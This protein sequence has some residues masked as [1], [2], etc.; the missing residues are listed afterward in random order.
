MFVALGSILTQN[1]FQR[2]FMKRGRK[3]A[4]SCPPEVEVEADCKKVARVETEEAVDADL[5]VPNPPS[6]AEL[7]ERLRENVIQHGMSPERANQLRVQHFRFFRVFC[8]GMFQM[9][10]NETTN[11]TR[12]TLL[13]RQQFVIPV[14]FYQALARWRLSERNGNDTDSDDRAEYSGLT[15]S[16]T[17]REEPIITEPQNP[18]DLTEEGQSLERMHD[19]IL[20]RS[21]IASSI[22]V[23]V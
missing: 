11:S 6:D 1:G 9:R 7:L 17:V 2:S 12:P 18:T 4:A 5:A 3:R 8:E 20:L 10:R 13:P 14:T 19:L 16:S 22:G 15:S 21:R 23:T